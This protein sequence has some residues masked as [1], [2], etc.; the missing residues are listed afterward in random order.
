MTLG[1]R[2]RVC[3][4]KLHKSQLD[5]SAD[6]GISNTQLS[7]YEA[8][9][10]KPDPELISKFAEYYKT[11][12]DYLLGRTNNPSPITDN[13]E[14]FEFEAFINNPEHGIF[15]KEYLEAPEERKKELMMLWKMIKD[16]EKGRKLGDRQGE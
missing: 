7:R 10:R 2:L 9:T 4:E 16:A 12:T 6:L 5:A 3:R 11:T 8:D 14:D 13:T 15:F 1:E